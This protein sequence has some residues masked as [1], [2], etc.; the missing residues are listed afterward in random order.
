VVG[1]IE[2]TGYKVDLGWLDTRVR[3]LLNDDNDA[4]PNMRIPYLL[5]R[6]SVL[7]SQVPTIGFVGFYEGPY[8]GVM[9]L[10]AQ[11]LA[12]T[13]A[14]LKPTKPMDLPDRD[15]YKSDATKQMRVAMKEKP[16]QIPQFWMADYVGLMEEFARE[17]K[18]TRD[19]SAFKGQTGPAFPSRYQGI[20]SSPE[21]K[22]VIKEVAD[23]IRAS[24]E[25]ARFVAAAVFTGMQGIWNLT[26]K[27]E[28]RTN[29]P[30]GTFTGTAHFHP[31]EPTSA[32]YYTAEYLYVEEGTF[33]M[34]TGLSFPAT[35]RYAYRYNEAADKITA[36]F[37]D[38]DNETV[39][40]LFN[41]W[42]FFAPQDKKRGWM[43]K[44]HHWCDPDTYR[45]TCEFRFRGAKIGRFM[46]QYQV[47]GPKKDY[48]HESWY[49]RP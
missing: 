42:N 9:E 30:G 25:D 28:S 6:G 13:W 1:I 10:Q 32:A 45:N 2:A 12:Q 4:A 46:I 24:N 19:D 21:A 22:E 7:A 23:I 47:E 37:V 26:R 17:T 49:K 5:S 33:T 41:T 8:W 20:E 43:A 31:R 18:T 40:T 3:D 38:E 36:W 48:S 15:V 34:D 16:L 27:I 11:F 35:R 44:G 39:S 14:Q 29:T